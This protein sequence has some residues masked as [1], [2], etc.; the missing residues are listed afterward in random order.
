VI[1]FQSGGREKRKHPQITQITQIRIE[2]KK[3]GGER[4]EEERNCSYR[5]TENTE[6][7]RE[8]GIYMDG[9]DLRDKRKGSGFVS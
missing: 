1:S 7:R 9:Q 4:Q 5:G 3:G 2:E 6:V 8:K